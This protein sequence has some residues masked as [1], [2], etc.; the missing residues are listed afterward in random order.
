MK[1]EARYSRCLNTPALPRGRVVSTP[2]RTTDQELIDKLD[3]FE[4]E[5]QK[6]RDDFEAYTSKVRRALIEHDGAEDR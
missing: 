2:V 6:F 4:K 1:E 3:D 5:L